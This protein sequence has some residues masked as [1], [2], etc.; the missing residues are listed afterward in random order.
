MAQLFAII[1]YWSL[2]EDN[3]EMVLNSPFELRTSLVLDDKQEIIECL[4]NELIVLNV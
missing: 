4:V 2:L 1:R 3:L